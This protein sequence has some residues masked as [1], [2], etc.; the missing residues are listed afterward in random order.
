MTAFPSEQFMVLLPDGYTR[1]AAYPLV[2]YHHGMNETMSGPRTNVEKTALTTAILAAG[3]LIAS[4]NSHGNHWGN[5]ASLADYLELYRFVTGTFR[6]SRTVLLSQSMGGQSG[7][8]TAANRP[9]PIQGW[10]GI[11]PVCSLATMYALGGGWDDSINAA[12][13]ISGDYA[14]KT[15]GH[16]PLLRAASDYAGLRLRFY[17]SPED[18][19]VVKTAHSDALSAHVA[20]VTEEEEV[21]ACEGNHGDASHFQSADLIAYLG[22]CV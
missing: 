10:A 17:A 6:V 8:L 19:V 7:L 12:Y 15:A 11:Y 5:A 14:A 18:T 22:R 2:I 9:F 21:V 4:S 3:Y 1:S 13:G 20:S 16:D